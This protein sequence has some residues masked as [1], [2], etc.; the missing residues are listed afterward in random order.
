MGPEGPSMFLV[1]SW[2]LVFCEISVAS[3]K[4]LIFVSWSGLLFYY[5]T[6]FFHCF[7]TNVHRSQEWDNDVQISGYMMNF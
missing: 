4:S 2:E 1:L 3:Q 5:S 6:A 7:V